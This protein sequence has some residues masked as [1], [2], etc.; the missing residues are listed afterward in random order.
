MLFRSQFILAMPR[1]IL[2]STHLR[3]IPPMRWYAK[4][5]FSSMKMEPAAR[6][7]TW[8]WQKLL[9]RRRLRFSATCPKTLI[10]CMANK[11]CRTVDFSP[12]GSFS[13]S[14]LFYIVQR[15]LQSRLFQRLHR[16]IFYGRFLLQILL[17]FN[18]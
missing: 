2:P 12:C 10:R 15:Y 6:Y 4:Q 8:I 18:G 16:L 9:R 14:F 5:A 3:T 17:H 7:S 13:V 1:L 11:N